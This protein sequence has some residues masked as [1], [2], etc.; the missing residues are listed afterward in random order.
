M[1]HAIVLDTDMGSDVDDALCLAL[2]VAAPEIELVAVTHVCGDT[3]LRA[4]ISRRLLDLAGRRDVPVYAGRSQA[5]DGGDRFV[6]FGHEGV[7][8]LDS[9]PAPVPDDDAVDILCRLLRARADLEVVA[10]GPLTNVAAALASDAAL[11]KRIA[12]LT[13]MGGYVRGVHYG[14]VTFPPAFDYN[15][16]ADPEASRVVLSAGIPTRIIPVDVTMQVWI[17]ERD[18][19]VLAASRA[20]LPRA[21]AA[22]VRRWTPGM[23]NAMVAA[24]ADPAI[25]NAA[26]LHDPLALACAYDESFCTFEDLWIEPCIA[27]GLFRTHERP[28]AGAGIHRIRCATA[29]DRDRFL[30]HFRARVVG[31]AP[32]QNWFSRFFG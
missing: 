18:V 28:Q 4:Q 7:G 26:F 23:T 9:V 25:D 10:V 1:P 24:G 21:L 20:G 12:Q 6:W 2:A 3:R 15:L 16:C 32:R 29:V 8:I 13:L 22:A 14:G 30:N 27:D 17:A 31:P 5:L 11:A 19:R